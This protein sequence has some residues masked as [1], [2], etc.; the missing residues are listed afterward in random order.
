MVDLQE[1]LA[2]LIRQARP[3][4]LAL[5]ALFGRD[6]R[7]GLLAGPGVTRSGRAVMAAHWRVASSPEVAGRAPGTARWPGGM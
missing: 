4:P 3:D 5:I 7:L 2:G 6:L 1:L